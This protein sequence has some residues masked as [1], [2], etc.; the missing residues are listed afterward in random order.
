MR[1]KLF[2]SLTA[3]ALAAALAMCMMGMGA[4]Y[5]AFQRDLKDGLVRQADTLAAL[6]SRQEDPVAF[7]SGGAYMNRVTLVDADGQVLYDS[8][9]AAS[10]MDNHQEREEIERARQTGEAFSVRSS[11]T[12]GEISIYYARLL[13]SGQVLR[14][15]GSQQSVWAALSGAAGWIV[16]AALLCVAAAALLARPVTRRLVAPINAIDLDH[17]LLSDAYEELS[18]VLRRMDQQN[19]R[20]E[21]QLDSL[22]SQRSELDIILGGMREGLILLDEKRA[23]LTM[24]AAARDMLGV[25]D[26]PVGKSVLQV[27]R[28]GELIRL[29]Q[30]GS[31]EGELAREG[32]RLHVSIS[33]VAQGGMVILL[34][35]VTDARQAEESRRQFTANVSHE[36]RTPLTTICGY[37]E[38][39]SSGMARAQDAGEMGGRILKEGRRLLSLIEDII[40]LSR[41]DEGVMNESAPV[42]LR[43]LT[44]HCLEKLRPLAKAQEITLS[45]EGGEATV[46]GDRVLLEEMLTNLIENGVKYNHPGGSVKVTVSETDGRPRI[47]VSDTGVGIAPEH[48]GRVFERFYRVD[49]SR[50][51]Q[52]GGTGLGLSIVKHGAQVHHA[53]IT[54]E[55]RVGQGTAITLTF[56]EQKT[57]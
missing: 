32:C 33:T 43:A 53:E 9:H 41:L 1:K 2:F 14:L 36:L 29:L 26:D 3:F 37:A 10:G 7:L 27:N 8:S 57:E 51:K 5:L 52:T 21:Q 42:A 20:I 47:Q 18:P 50:S 38:L 15:S 34:Q 30:A 23:V 25:K 13:P 54:L 31:G 28:S 35:D 24:N 39:L 11:T 4:L 22:R 48:Q 19:R 55:S 16:L 44:D 45:A 46:Q 40:R 17:P 49:K 12:V 56:P 6:L